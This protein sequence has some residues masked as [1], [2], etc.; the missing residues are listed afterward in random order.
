MR[1]FKIAQIIICIVL[2][3]FLFYYGRGVCIDLDESVVE[4][5]TPMYSNSAM[6]VIENEIPKGL[7][8]PKKKVVEVATIPIKKD[9]VVAKVEKPSRS[10]ESRNLIGKFELTAYC[11]CT[12][13]CGANAKGITASGTKVTKGRTIAVDTNVIPMGS[14]VY[15]EGVGERVAEDRGGAIK[16]NRIDVYFG[17]HQE[18]LNFGRRRGI[19]V[20]RID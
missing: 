10:S 2:A 14:K 12:K 7:P 16:G 11:A 3:I 15:I 20:Y 13:C 18:A 8:I 4:Y 6:E 9:R 17:S 5:V 1:N 19:E